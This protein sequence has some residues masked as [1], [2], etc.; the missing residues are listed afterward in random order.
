MPV[1]VIDQI[2]A[3]AQ[4]I[5]I[6]RLRAVAV[7]ALDTVADEIECAPRARSADLCFQVTI[8]NKS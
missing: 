3:V 1:A 2:E 7:D 5:R 8:E 4:V 6:R